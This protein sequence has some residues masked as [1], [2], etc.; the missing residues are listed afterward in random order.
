MRFVV[1]CVLACGVIRAQ[2]DRDFSGSWQLNRAKSEI[3][4]EPSPALRVQQSATALSVEAAGRTFTYPL[5]GSTVRSGP[6]SAATKW[7]GSA[8]LVN[9]LASGPPQHT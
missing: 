6:F 5:D 7:E 3:R 4:D 2:T 9:I 8:L 1:A